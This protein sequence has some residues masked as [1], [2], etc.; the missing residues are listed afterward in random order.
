MIFDVLA[1][2]AKPSA[3]ADEAVV[4]AG[5]LQDFVDS[6]VSFGSF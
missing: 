1:M 5:Q 4:L 3:F 2:K 6:M